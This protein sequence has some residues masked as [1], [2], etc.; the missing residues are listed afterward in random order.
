VARPVRIWRS[1]LRG[2]GP[3]LQRRAAAGSAPG[4]ARGGR[5]VHLL[6]AV[7]TPR[8]RRRPVNSPTRSRSGRSTVARSIGVSNGID[9]SIEILDRYSSTWAHSRPSRRPL[10]EGR[11]LYQVFPERFAN[12]ERLTTRPDGPVGLGAFLV[13][14]Q[15][16]D[17][18]GIT[19][20]LDYLHDL[21]VEILYLTPIF[22]SPSTHKYDASDFYHVDPAFGGNGA[23]AGVNRWAPPP[24]HEDRPRRFLQH[25]HPRFF[26]FQDLVQKGPDSRY[27]DWF[28]VREW[29]VR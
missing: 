10:G 14:F 9:H 19:Q 26:A 22:T 29:P 1:G 21:G 3:R 28:T 18:Q 7:I 13:E 24:G 27:K 15:G 23:L 12:G 16:G 5:P 6:G 4:S 8:R 2:R 17:L 11:R 25:C 20:K